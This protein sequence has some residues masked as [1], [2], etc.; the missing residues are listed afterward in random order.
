MRVTF[1]FES[2]SACD[3]K[4]CGAAAYAEHPSTEVICCSIKVDGGPSRI[5]LPDWVLGLFTRAH[6]EG[7]FTDPYVTFEPL[8]D[9]ELFRIFEEADELES[10]NN[11]FEHAVWLYCCTKKYGWPKPPVEKFRC[12]LA[13]CSYHALPRTLEQACQALGVPIQKD[14]AGHALMLKLCRPR[15]PVKAE[16]IGLR[17]QGFVVDEQTK[18]VFDGQTGEQIYLWHELPEQFEA[19]IR[20]CL[21]DTDAEHALSSALP[22]LPESELRI[23]QLDQ[24]INM[25]GIAA[26]IPAAKR[27]VEEIGKLETRLLAETQQ[28]TDGAVGSP[29]QVA[30]ALRWLAEQ[31]VNL[32]DLT[33]NNVAGA[34]KDENCSPEVRHFLELRQQLGR[35]S[36]AKY[37]A[38]INA[39]NEDGRIRGTGLYHGAGTGR[40][41]GKLVQP[42]NLPRGLFKDVNSCIEHTVETGFDDTFE[43]LWGDVMGAAST[44]IRG[45]LVASDGNDLVTADFSSI[46]GRVI[47]WLADEESVLDGYRK[48]LDPYIV[49]ASTVYNVRYEDISKKSPKRQTGKCINLG[50]GFGGGIGAFRSMA[51]IYRVDLE[52]LP[53]HV[54]PLASAEMVERAE[55]NASNYLKKNPGDMTREAAIACDVVK[56][57]WRVKRP[58]IVK[59]WYGLEEAAVLAVK[60]PGRAYRYGKI[61]YKSDEQFLRCKLPSGRCLHYFNPGFQKKETPWGAM[62]EVI[63]YYGVDSVTRKFS[64]MH[65]Y[66]GL[67]AENC[68]QAV[69]RDLLAAAL[70]RSEDRG[71]PVVL[72]VHD[73]IVAD[74]KKGEGSLKEFEALISEVPEW[75]TGLPIAAEGW[76]GHRYRK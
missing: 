38:I 70:I 50:L 2:R 44:C 29:K 67:L 40:W 4:K 32:P 37:Q 64:K 61:V 23:W 75:A 39:A 25:R 58:N 9:E 42:Q 35:A 55:V 30:A 16:I 51:A 49:D 41:S 60:N 3:I 54:L 28:V 24:K 59:L 63:I 36:T 8:S 57:L 72:H 47:A 46:E 7:E 19:L 1:D 76:V 62:K 71:Y 33:K 27:F 5:W 13:K 26:D 18:E 21:N 17:E 52:E 15:K 66:S 56:Q 31:G 43:M 22:D 34:L 20:Y 45:L 11:F 74:R 69:A 73:E 12:S 10:H 53:Q 14:M 6:M 68:T 48:G 65:L